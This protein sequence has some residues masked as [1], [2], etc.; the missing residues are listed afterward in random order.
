MIDVARQECIRIDCQQNP[1]ES[2]SRVKVW[3]EPAT[4]GIFKSPKI[5]KNII[6]VLNFILP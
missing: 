2:E 1:S 6:P 5:H 4:L 3:I